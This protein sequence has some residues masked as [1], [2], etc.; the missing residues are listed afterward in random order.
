[1]KRATFIFATSFLSYSSLLGQHISPYPPADH[2]IMTCQMP[3]KGTKHFLLM[4]NGEVT[5]FGPGEQAVLVEG[6][7]DVV[8]IAAGNSHMLALRG[9]GT[10]WSWGSNDEFQSGNKSSQKMDVVNSPVEVDGIHNAIA[11]SAMY[12]TSYA[13]LKDGAIVAWGNGNMGMTGDGQPLTYAGTSAFHS[14]R[15]APVKVQNINNAIAISGAMALLSN[16]EVMTWGD[17]QYGRLGN[18]SDEPTTIPAKVRGIEHAVAI[19]SAGESALALLANGEVWAWGT[20]FKGQLGNGAQHMDQN[21]HSSQPVQVLGIKNAISI[22][23]HCT[24]FALMK[25]SSIMGW[26]WS[27]LG[28]LGSKKGDENSIPVRIPV[29]GKVI[30]VKAGNALG[31]A[32]MDDGKIIGWG[33]DMVTKGDYHQTYSPIR[34]DSVGI[35]VPR[36]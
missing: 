1:M 13:L 12:N 27:E 28:A 30:A 32:M 26:G 11:I 5:T 33:S 18:G 15:R 4:P 10:V 35:H 24:C 6:L 17:G 3:G 20:N 34:I 9:D 36:R 29:K 31:F 14:A 7:K 21:E 8:S 16:G 2:W 19:S 25:D 23:A 22:S